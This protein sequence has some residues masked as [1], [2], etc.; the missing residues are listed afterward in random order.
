LSIILELRDHYS[1]AGTPLV[2]KT[3]EDVVL[4]NVFGIVKNLEHSSV[5]VPWIRQITGLNCSGAELSV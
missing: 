3:S 5:L 1:H 4:S 2:H